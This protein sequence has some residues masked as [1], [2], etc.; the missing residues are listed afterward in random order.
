MRQRLLARGLLLVI[1]AMAWTVVE[2]GQAPP[3]D[4]RKSRQELE[5]MRGILQTTLKFSSQED[6]GEADQSFAPDWRAIESFYL[7]GQG[8]VFILPIPSYRSFFPTEMEHLEDQLMDMEMQREVS[9]AQLRSLERRL[10]RSARLAQLRGRLGYSDA[11]R[12]MA[13]A[14]AAIA[15]LGSAAPP[16]PPQPPQPPSPPSPQLAP[17]PELHPRE[18]SASQR[19]ASREKIRK[20]LQELE[21]RLAERK[22]ENARRGRKFDQLMTRTREDLIEAVAKHGGSLSVVKPNEFVTL[23]LTSEGSS[24]RS[25]RWGQTAKSATVVSVPKSEIARYNAGQITLKALKD[26][27]FTYDN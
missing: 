26:A 11:S 12:E 20:R 7:Y 19:E 15:A 22:K 27:V 21:K 25:G 9:E 1:I 13:T 18:P 24:R 3:F 4:S 23:I 6:Q 17:A 8:A 2:A 16:E 10:E 5:I 14:S